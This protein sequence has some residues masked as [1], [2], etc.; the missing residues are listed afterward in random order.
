MQA[1]S[2]TV[3]VVEGIDGAGKSTQCAR[4]ADRLT[5]RG[6][7]VVLSRPDRPLRRVYKSLTDDA[8]TFPDARTSVLLGLADYSYGARPTAD[9]DVVLLDRYAYSSC[10]DALAL[11]MGLDDVL[12]LLRMFEPPDLT[13]LVDVSPRQALA[14][15][16]WTCSLAEAGG[17]DVVA[18]AASL[19][20]SFVAYQSAVRDAYLRLM[21][22][23]TGR[24]GFD[25]VDG[26]QP[27]DDVTDR[28]VEA[29]LR[30]C[31]TG[32]AA[33]DA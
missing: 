26:D 29:V 30:A 23:H 9:V 33:V 4:V 18:R 10:A 22:V 12:P 32:L 25:L 8:D 14:R 19:Q 6:L 3:V 31:G 28:L 11:G 13:L 27:V 7:R 17:P 15:K 5:A 20:D 1:S 2:P 24:H 16:G 21:A